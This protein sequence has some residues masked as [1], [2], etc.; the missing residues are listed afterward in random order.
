MPNGS[1]N[2]ERERQRELARQKWQAQL[3]RRSI[4]EPT[5]QRRVLSP[6][7]IPDETRFI[8]SQKPEATTAQLRAERA[9][10]VGRAAPT[11]GV[12]PKPQEFGGPVR[13][14]PEPAGGPQ[15]TRRELSPA[16]AA[17]YLR[18]E[19]AKEAALTGALQPRPAGP[20]L[21]Q[22]MKDRVK[23]LTAKF[24]QWVWKTVPGSFGASLL[25]LPVY[26]AIAYIGQFIEKGFCRLGEEWF[27]GGMP[28]GGGAA[29]GA[30]TATA[31]AGAAGA[32]GAGAVSGAAGV[33]TA[34][35]GAAAGAAG[36]AGK[37]PI[38]P[39]SPGQADVG[40][41]AAGAQPP[42]PAQAI[43][44]LQ[45]ALEYGEVG[46]ANFIALLFLFIILLICF[47]IFAVVRPIEFLKKIGIWESVKLIW[48][49]V[50]KL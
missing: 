4:E 42:G 14:K 5:L 2:E 8:N 7:E 35:G 40:G 3:K 1:T 31:G 46:L 13:P 39:Q 32:A 26:F 49:M 9:R 37:P 20:D 41:A 30:G 16:E 44:L 33:A 36:A 10:E 47:I 34:G 17:A 18:G 48:E 50:N 15:I 25:L 38:V 11:D 24:L 28:G 43:G 45:K 21:S 27:A 12:G 23:N 19:R 6:G 22:L 29:A